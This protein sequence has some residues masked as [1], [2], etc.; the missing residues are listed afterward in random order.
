[1]NESPYIFEINEKNYQKIVI[2]G[3]ES[4]PVLVDFWAEWC[5]PCKMLMPLLAKL[6]DEYQGK[7]LLAKLNTEEQQA[8][9]MQFGIRSIPT[10]KVFKNGQPVD[11]FM[12]A[13]P[14]NQ[15]R[16]FLDKH[17]PRESDGL[18]ARADEM[19][20][21]GDLDGAAAMIEQARQQDPQSPRV[22]LADA[23]IKSIQGEIEQAQEVLSA[24]PPDVQDSPEAVSLKA[25]L[26][27]QQVLQN[28]PA[29]RDLES[30]V[31]NDGA[32]SED[33]YQLAAHKV[34]K[35]DYETALELLLKL[36]QKDRTYGDDAGRRGML[37]VFDI[38]GASNPLVARYR[39]RMFNALH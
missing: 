13:L 25:N 5:Q 1:M 3:S 22:L 2:E 15:I 37:A 10:V 8:I 4:V 35:G 18:L 20:R 19:S 24:L 17:I 16:A 30:R 39:G 36:L 9:A 26:Q 14:E 29:E 27:F 28:A 12:G 31:S 32:D 7:F 11:E 38:I 33:I 34:R 6:V 21:L 23:A